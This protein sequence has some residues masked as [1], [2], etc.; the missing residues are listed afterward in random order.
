MKI[1]ERKKPVEKDSVQL[2]LRK[3]YNNPNISKHTVLTDD[4][5]TYVDFYFKTNKKRLNLDCNNA[6][7][8]YVT[9]WHQ[10]QNFYTAAKVLPVESSPLPMYYCMLNAAKAYCLYYAADPKDIVRD[11]HQ[12]GICEG[13]S[14]HFEENSRKRKSLKEIFVSRKSYGVF[15]AFSKLLDQKFEKNWEQSEVFSLSQL[16]GS[17]AFV[18]SAYSSTYNITREQESFIPLAARESP[19]FYFC[20]DGKI[21]LVVPLQKS[22]FSKN[23]V[24]LPQKIVDSLPDKLAVSDFDPFCLIST[25]TILKKEIK[26]KHSEYRAL[27]SE[28]TADMP[29]WY[30]NKTNNSLN[31]INDLSKILAVTHRLSEIVRYKPEQMEELLNGKE[32]WLLHEFI[33]LALDQF[34]D[35]I[36]CEITKQEIM[37]TRKK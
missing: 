6:N 29:I 5:F 24:K 28:I 1:I 17:L 10:A 19:V 37:P 27:F 15:S 34:I 35:K 7:V 8:H 32:N 36:S 31:N 21:H 23:S 13:N 2:R 4:A 12:H 30:L 11:L 22:Y 9:Y 25:E 18:H 20:S 14:N 26:K 16:L 3:A 33:L